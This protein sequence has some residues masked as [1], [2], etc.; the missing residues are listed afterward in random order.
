MAKRDL[1]DF[2]GGTLQ[3]QVIDLQLKVRGKLMV[4]ADT[5]ADVCEQCGM[6]YFSDEVSER[7]DETL[8]ARPAQ[9]PVRYLRVPVYRLAGVG[10]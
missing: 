4:F 1:C 2:C 6:E 7:I 9:R 5:P 3:P 10:S 8:A